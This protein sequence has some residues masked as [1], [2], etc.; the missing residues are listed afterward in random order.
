M[1]CFNEV[2]RHWKT[3]LIWVTGI[4][5]GILFALLNNGIQ[6]N[7]DYQKAV[8]PLNYNWIVIVPIFLMMAAFAVVG[9]LAGRKYDK[10]S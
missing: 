9:F 10:D 3:I 8:A 7:Q 1:R 6:A 2:L 4:T 5:I